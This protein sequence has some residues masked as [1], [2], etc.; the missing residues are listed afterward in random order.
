MTHYFK[1]DPNLKHNRKQIVF[2]FLGVD[3]ILESDSGVFSKDHVDTGTAIML[4]SIVD[5][6][7][8]E[9]TFLD[10]GCGYGV[11]ACVIKSLQ[12]HCNVVA[13]DINERAI[14]L[15]KTNALKNNLDIQVIHSDGFDNIN[16]TLDT[17]AFNPPIKVG[18]KKMYALLEAC[19]THLNNQGTLVVVIRKDQGAKS[20]IAYLQTLFKKVRII[21]KRK[22][23]WVISCE[24]T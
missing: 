1:N 7:S 2:R 3:Y 22:G 6:P 11:V 5:S 4:Q 21:T 16:Q 24:K 14:E 18:K 12:P 17:I 8:N 23:F 10:L 13:S 9:G 15:C 20:A 19:H